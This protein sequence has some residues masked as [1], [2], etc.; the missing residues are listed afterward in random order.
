MNSQQDQPPRTIPPNRRYAST[1]KY[2]KKICVIGDSHIRQ[3]RKNILNNSLNNGRAYLNS[4]NGANI[5]RLD[6]FITSILD[7]DRPVIFIFHEGCNYIIHNSVDYINV[8]DISKCLTEICKSFRV[9]EVIFSSILVRKQLKLTQVI[10]QVNECLC[11]S[12][13]KT[14]FFLSM[15]TTSPE[16]IYG[17][18]VCI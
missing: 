13:K 5:K 1:I 3:I 12:V 14:I 16:N 18:M 8:K 10:R 4:F 17:E 15:T 6:L 11:E 2:G 9:K 7:E